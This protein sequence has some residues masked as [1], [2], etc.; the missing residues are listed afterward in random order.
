[1]TIR[2]K[3]TLNPFKARAAFHRACAIAALH[4][5]S[6]VSV[7]LKRYNAAMEKA[8]AAEV[9]GGIVRSLASVGG[10]V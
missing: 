3:L 8:H 7:R 1:M 9:Q 6:S 10:T 4:A 2:Q 5:D